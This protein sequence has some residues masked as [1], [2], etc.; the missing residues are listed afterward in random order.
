M[1]RFGGIMLLRPL[2]AEFG[3]PRVLAYVAGHP[4][5]IEEDSVHSSSLRYQ[6]R[7][8]EALIAERRK[9]ITY[10]QLPE[11]FKMDDAG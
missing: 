11:Q 7:A 3:V 9:G 8:R 6:E 4:M 1:Q 10:A 2:I 5:E